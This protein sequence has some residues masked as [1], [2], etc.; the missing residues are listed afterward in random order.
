MPAKPYWLVEGWSTFV[1]QALTHRVHAVHLEVNISMPDDPG[2][3]T[4]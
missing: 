1:G 2:G 3:D 4:G